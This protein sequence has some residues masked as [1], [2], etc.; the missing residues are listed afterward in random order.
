MDQSELETSIRH[1]DA[2]T[3]R[4]EERT[5]RIE[6]RMATIEER[7]M[8]IEERTA[9]IEERTAGV[10][11]RTIRI[12]QTFLTKEDAK[13]FATKDDVREEGERTRRHFDI[14]ADRMK[15]DIALIAEGHKATRVYVDGQLGNT[16]TTLDSHDKRITKLE[17][18]SINT[19]D[20]PKRRSTRRDP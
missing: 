18:K 13:V 11:E 15:E 5:T 19:G 8:S 7:T 20:K 4:I 9:G 17:A 2:R 1:I 3:K 16:R 12:E 6:E 14:V 10:E